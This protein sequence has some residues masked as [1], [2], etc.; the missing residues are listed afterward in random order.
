MSGLPADTEFPKVQNREG[1]PELA[2]NETLLGYKERL[3]IWV[4][5]TAL[6]V[7]QIVA[8]ILAYGFIYRPEMRTKRSNIYNK[9]R[10]E[11]VLF[12][13]PKEVDINKDIKLLL[14]K[15]QHVLDLFMQKLMEE[16]RDKTGP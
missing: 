13:D 6:H 16:N 11:F 12:P 4:I 5:S 3:E 2:K 7:H 14:E 15:K 8:T 9:Y 1:L 10:H